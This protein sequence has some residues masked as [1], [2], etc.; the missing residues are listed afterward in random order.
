MSLP[1]ADARPH[2]CH[3]LGFLPRSRVSLIRPWDM[4]FVFIKTLGFFWVFYLPILGFS[5]LY[6]SNTARRARPI[7]CY[8]TRRQTSSAEVCATVQRCTLSRPTVAAKAVSRF[9]PLRLT[10]SSC[11]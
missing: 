10:E 9:C 7:L 5:F 3:F 8:S 1:L 2:C 11:N 6:S 4:G